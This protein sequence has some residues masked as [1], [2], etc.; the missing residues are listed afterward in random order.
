MIVDKVG[1]MTAHEFSIENEYKNR[2]SVYLE[3]ECEVVNIETKPVGEE[4]EE[5]EVCK[6]R[7]KMAKLTRMKDGAYKDKE[8]TTTS[9][10]SRS[11]SHRSLLYIYWQQQLSKKYT[12]EAFYDAYYDKRDAEIK[13]KL[14]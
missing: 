5:K 2:D 10:N 9:R 7:I 14:Q 6:L 3:A 1:K 11:Q 12:F 4:E 13:E 8:V